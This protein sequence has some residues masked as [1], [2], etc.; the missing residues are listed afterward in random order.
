M[1]MDI[2]TALHELL[3]T[4]PVARSDIVRAYRR[5]AIRFHPDK[6][7]D[8][9]EKR[10][11]QHKFVE[12]QEAYE[13]LKDLPI[14][15]IN[16]PPDHK[17]SQEASGLPHQQPGE[18]PPHETHREEPDSRDPIGAFLGF[19]FLLAIIF[20]INLVIRFV[21]GPQRLSGSP[22]G[23]KM[24]DRQTTGSAGDMRIEETTLQQTIGRLLTIGYDP[25]GACLAYFERIKRPIRD[26][27]VVCGVKVHVLTDRVTFNE[28]GLEWTCRPSQ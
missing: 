18:C 16:T 27:Q 23:Q 2:D 22:T 26:G 20:A 15:T 8:A 4:R 5:M 19:V 17:M 9:D 1:T 12:V 3:L 13:L 25:N 10:W 11:A 28:Y 24:T 6:T 7:T 14:D 21:S